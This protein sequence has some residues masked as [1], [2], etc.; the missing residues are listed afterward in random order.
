[1]FPPRAHLWRSAFSPFL[2]FSLNP[3]IPRPFWRPTTETDIVKNFNKTPFFCDK[4]RFF[5]V[6]LFP[7]IFRY[8]RS[9]SS[10]LAERALT[11]AKAFLLFKLASDPKLLCLFFYS[12]PESKLISACLSPP[13]TY[14]FLAPFRLSEV[15]KTL[16]PRW[17]I[18]DFPF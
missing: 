16:S 2:L 5:Y 14:F 15:N 8:W 4:N 9:L 10:L 12:L 13:V 18:W 17:L 7:R 1:V 11:F 6:V 3:Q